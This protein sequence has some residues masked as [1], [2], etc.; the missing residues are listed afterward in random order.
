M[1]LF[2]PTAL[3]YISYGLTTV[4]FETRHR[5][6]HTPRVVRLKSSQ[7]MLM[8]ISKLI[9]LKL[10]I[11]FSNVYNYFHIIISFITHF[12]VVISFC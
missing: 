8:F 10:K 9:A 2:I 1:F 4:N 12:I 3:L 7:F 5:K 6:M 11:Y